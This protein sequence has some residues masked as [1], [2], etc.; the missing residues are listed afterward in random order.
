VSVVVDLA[1]LPAQIERFGPRALL[2]TTSAGGP[3]HVASVV[4]RVAGDRLEMG[5]GRKTRANATERPEVVVVWIAPDENEHCLVL[6]GRA[7]ETA[8][9]ELAV[10]PTSAVLHRLAGAPPG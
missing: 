10:T 9:G 4:V 2:V 8:A 3:P 1:T 6:D 7:E 5:A